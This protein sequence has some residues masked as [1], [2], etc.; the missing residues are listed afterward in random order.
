MNLTGGVYSLASLVFLGDK[1]KYII[2]ALNSNK[3]D[4]LVEFKKKVL[5]FPN[6]KHD[7][8]RRKNN[9]YPTTN[10]LYI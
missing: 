4:F 2:L 6:Y 8:K 9:E 1:M 7:R 5:E 3:K 10:I